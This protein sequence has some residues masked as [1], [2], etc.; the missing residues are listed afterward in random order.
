[1]QEKGVDNKL[2]QIDIIQEEKDDGL[3]DE[4]LELYNPS[5]QSLQH[6]QQHQ[7]K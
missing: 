4:S 2:Y 1:V 6:Q 3:I 5:M 7:P